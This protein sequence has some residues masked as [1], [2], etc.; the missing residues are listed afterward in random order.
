MSPTTAEIATENS[1]TKC[2]EKEDVFSLTLVLSQSETEKIR[3]LSES[4]RDEAR[5]RLVEQFTA[6]FGWACE[7]TDSFIPEPVVGPFSGLRF[8]DIRSIIDF[9][10]DVDRE[11]SMGVEALDVILGDYRHHINFEAGKT[12]VNFNVDEAIGHAVC[13]WDL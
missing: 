5:A 13:E 2:E 11:H 4:N 1:E 7:E 9:I 8:R 6:L 3:K 10:A 12:G